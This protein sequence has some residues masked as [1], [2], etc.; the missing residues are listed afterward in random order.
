MTDQELIEHQKIQLARAEYVVKLQMAEI[1]RLRAEVDRLLGWINGD[2]DA[3]TALQSIYL[4]PDESSANRVKA[5]SAAIGFERP[6][7]VIQ[8]YANVTSLARRLDGAHAKVIEHQ[9][10]PC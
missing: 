1:D 3:L 8:G 6:K 4:N 10:D 7:V 5:A 2:G 9:P